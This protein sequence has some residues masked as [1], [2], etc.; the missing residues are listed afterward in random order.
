MSV[1]SN[2]LLFIGSS[3]V[4]KKFIVQRMVESNTTSNNNAA[5]STTTPHGTFHLDNKYYTAS[6]ELH[7]LPSS[8]LENSS[9]NDT[10]TTL[11]HRFDTLQPQAMVGVFSLERPETFHQLVS[12]WNPATFNLDVMI[13][14]GNQFKKDDSSTTTTS[15]ISVNEREEL[16]QLAQDWA[17]D[18]AVEYVRMP[19]DDRLE[20]GPNTVQLAQPKPGNTRRNNDDDDDDDEL[21][22]AAEPMGLRRIKESLECNTWPVMVMKDRRAAVAAAHAALKNDEEDEDDE[23]E[24]KEAAAF[25]SMQSESRTQV[26]QSTSSSSTSASSTSSAAVAAPST[27]T[28]APA[29][30]TAPRSSSASAFANAFASAIRVPDEKTQSAPAHSP[31][32]SSSVSSAGRPGDLPAVDPADIDSLAL[33]LSGLTPSEPADVGGDTSDLDGV[34][35]DKLFERIT[36]M[37]AQLN[38]VRADGTKMSDEERRAK[39][40]ENVR[41]LLISMGMEGELESDIEEDEE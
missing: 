32:S 7:V 16:D 41:A 40:E 5:S 18:H 15:M 1:S 4:G 22:A 36:A 25:A 26:E 19:I 2:S 35:F 12:S 6:I 20:A 28:S 34:N 31:S 24:A 27:A 17:I 38:A 10:N 39:A 11:S 8:E 14:V 13:L 9:S 37:K 30:A 29:S 23:N 21:D 3:Q 33:Q